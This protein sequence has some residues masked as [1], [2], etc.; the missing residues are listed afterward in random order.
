MFACASECS[1]TELSNRF[2]ILKGSELFELLG[3]LG[4]YMAKTAVKSACS[5]ALLC[6]LPPRLGGVLSH[7]CCAL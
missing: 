5:V 6:S 3:S 2:S 7:M 1:A 4:R